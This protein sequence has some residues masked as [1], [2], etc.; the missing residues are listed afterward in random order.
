LTAL[1]LSPVL[2]FCPVPGWEVW[3][4]LL[5]GAGLFWAFNMAD[6]RRLSARVDMNLVYPVM[7]GAAP[8]IA[9]VF[10]IFHLGER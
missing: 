8:A 4:F 2:I 7:R 1:W 5:I 3:R 9:G 10:A 6:D